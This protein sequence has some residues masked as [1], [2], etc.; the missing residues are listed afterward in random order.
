[1]IFFLYTFSD[2][3]SEILKKNY[4][5]PPP[6]MDTSAKIPAICRPAGRSL[7]FGKIT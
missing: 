7:G 1:M 3:L 2:A 5:T 6:I 4:K